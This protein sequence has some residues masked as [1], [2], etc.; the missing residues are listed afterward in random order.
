M[1]KLQFK[2]SILDNKHLHQVN[3]SLFSFEDDG[4][5]I[6]YSPALDLS[7]YGNTE[8]EAKASFEEALK[9]FLRYTTHKGTFT[10]ELKRLG[11]EVG[12]RLKKSKPAK[13]PD[14]AHMLQTNDYLARIFETKNFK[15]FNEAIELPV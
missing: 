4:S 15:K 13:A 12:V 7:G 11:W 9:E 6:V 8:K 14:L 10:K 3:L 5:K 1:A 2:G